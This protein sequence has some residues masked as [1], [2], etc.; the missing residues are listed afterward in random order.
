M[1][2]DRELD[3]LMWARI[4]LLIEQCVKAQLPELETLE[5][6]KNEIERMCELDD[7][8]ATT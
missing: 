3:A 5:I 6:I 8:N 7:D 4:D 2:P 1:E